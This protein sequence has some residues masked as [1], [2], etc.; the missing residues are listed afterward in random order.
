MISFERKRRL[1]T[2]A[3]KYIWF[4]NEIEGLSLT[5]SALEVWMYSVVSVRT[6]WVQ[7]NN[8]CLE[9]KGPQKPTLCDGDRTRQI[10]YLFVVESQACIF[11]RR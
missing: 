11:S 1:G 5:Y 3:S 9:P 2:L 6:R 4:V 7:I 10:C 8:P